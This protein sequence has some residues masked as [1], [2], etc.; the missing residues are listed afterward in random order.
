MS[1]R[2]K[3]T[4]Y[5]TKPAPEVTPTLPQWVRNVPGQMIGRTV[6]VTAP[7]RPGEIAGYANPGRNPNPATDSQMVLSWAGR[8]EAPVSVRLAVQCEWDWPSTT[9][10]AFQWFPK[11][12]AALPAGANLRLSNGV[13]PGAGGTIFNPPPGDF[14]FL[15]IEYGAGGALQTLYC[16]LRDTSIDLPP[17]NFVRV[18]AWRYPGGALDGDFPLPFTLEWPMKVTAGLHA[19]QNGA[20]DGDSA[21]LFSFGKFNIDPDATTAVRLFMPPHSE[22]FLFGIS[23]GDDLAA[24]NVRGCLQTRAAA[25]SAAP[26]TGTLNFP[27]WGPG[28]PIV[29]TYR[30]IGGGFG[31]ALGAQEVEM[32]AFGATEGCVIYAGVRVKV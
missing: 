25:I 13:P 4:S 16:D 3:A 24:V 9:F 30:D 7:P 2:L 28:I 14:G 22:S 18:N 10:G 26:A 12:M 1:D 15:Q 31:A 17:V 8:T 27:F 5:D 6:S 32:E 23:E 21:P 11:P 20:S 29:P 19:G